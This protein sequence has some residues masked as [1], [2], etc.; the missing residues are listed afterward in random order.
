MS[1]A[2]FITLLF[3]FFVVLFAVSQV[4]VKKMGRFTE[5]VQDATNVGVFEVTR[6]RRPSSVVRAQECLCASAPLVDAASVQGGVAGRRNIDTIRRAAN[7]SLSCC[8]RRRTGDAWSSTTT[9]WWCGCAMPP[10]SSPP[11]R[12]CDVRSCRT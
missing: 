7:K 8:H 9:V 1:Y 6:A 3:A 10:S 2:D 12:G 5:A 11:R 4:D